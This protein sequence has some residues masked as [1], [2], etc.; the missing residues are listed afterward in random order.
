MNQDI[1]VNQSKLGGDKINANP[2]SE[3]DDQTIE[4]AAEP[5]KN[6]YGQILKS[7]ALI[8]GSSII[9]IGIRIIRTKA[10]ALIL[11]PSGVGLMGLYESIIYTKH[12]RD[13]G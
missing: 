1:S 9:N 7:S 11:G 6:T 5:D 13:G 8:G 10:M 3:G 2:S 12:C 4:D